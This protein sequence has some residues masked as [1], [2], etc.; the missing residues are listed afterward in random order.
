MYMIEDV[1][2]IFSLEVIDELY[3]IEVWTYPFFLKICKPK[4][5]FLIPVHRGAMRNIEKHTLEVSRET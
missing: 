3:P 5:I 4:Q 1:H 2:A